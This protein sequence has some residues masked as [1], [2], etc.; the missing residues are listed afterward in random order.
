MTRNIKFVDHIADIAVDLEADSLEELFKAASE[1]YKISVTDF[2]CHN[3]S[4]FMEIEITGNSKEELLVNF[5]NEINFFL[6]TKEWLC[7]SIESIKIISDENSLELSAE[8]SGVELNSE[9]ELKQ[10][11]KSVTY[12]QM[13]IEEK[14]KFYTTRIVFDI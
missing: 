11:I 4:D 3:S 10:E 1:A 9:I 5:L 8:L 2:D 12:H 7:C 14:N 6:T 13:M